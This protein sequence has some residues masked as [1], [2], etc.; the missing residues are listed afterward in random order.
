[1]SAVF[2]SMCGIRSAPESSFQQRKG[3]DTCIKLK[4]GDDCD[5]F[6][7]CSHDHYYVCEKD[8]VPCRSNGLVGR[9]KRS[10][11][12]PCPADHTC[13]NLPG[14][15][16]CI[17]PFSC[18]DGANG[19]CSHICNSKEQK[20][21]CPECSILDSDGKTCIVDPSTIQVSCSFHGIDVRIS[22]GCILH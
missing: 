22:D 20:C 9:R 11:E 13:Q 15:Y 19:G 1:M 17:P 21:E 2:N 8:G 10:L 7:D 5:L 14:S 3:P 16:E 18:F 12:D 6:H 4:K